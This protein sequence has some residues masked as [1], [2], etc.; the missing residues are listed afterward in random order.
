MIVKIGAFAC[1]FLTIKNCFYNNL[2]GGKTTERNT[3]NSI[4][5][6]NMCKFSLT[7]KWSQNLHTIYIRIQIEKYD[8][9]IWKVINS[10]CR[11]NYRTQT[12]PADF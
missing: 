9:R 2:I 8:T 5:A 6:V 11:L 7:F 1:R 4:I 10:T 12:P 3:V